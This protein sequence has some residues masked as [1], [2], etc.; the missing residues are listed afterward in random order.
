MWNGGRPRLR[1]DLL[2]R[3]KLQGGLALPNLLH[4]Y[5]A[6]NV[7]K[8]L[9]WLHAPDTDWCRFEATSCNSTSLNALVTS[10]LPLSISNFTDNPIVVNTIKIW[11]QLRQSF[12][13]YNFLHISPICNNHSFPPARLDSEFS[14]WQR[15]GIYKFKDMYI[16]GLFASFHELVHKFDLPRSSLFRYFQVCHFLQHSDPNFPGLPSIPGLDDIL[17]LSSNTKQLISRIT[18]CITSLKNKSLVKIREDWVEEL[19][20]DIEEDMW[21]SA[22]QRVNDSSSCARL[23]IIQFKVVH[24]AHFS[25]ARLSKIYPNITANCDRCHNAPANLTH[26][27]WS[28]PVLAP[29]WSVIFE[30]LSKAL[31][32]DLQPNAAAAIFGIIDRRQYTITRGHENIIAFTTLL[33]RRRILLH[34]KSKNPPKVSAWLSDLMQFIQLEKIKYSLRGSRDEFFLTWGPVLKYL[35]GLKVLP[36]IT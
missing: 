25:K 18:D 3:P 12:R 27:F 7:Q 6:S 11:V 5:W 15:R 28:C 1:L 33:A 16:N 24:R 14:L 22:L 13:F 23:G 21:I 29:F 34:W 17:D 4:Y 10:S 8:I 31:H 26:M 2:Q 20:E 36:N 35:D 30:T 19:G 32:I 9:Y